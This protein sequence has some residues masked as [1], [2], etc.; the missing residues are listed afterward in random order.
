MDKNH[1]GQQWQRFIDI[2]GEIYTNGPQIRWGASVLLVYGRSATIETQSMM[3]SAAK[4]RSQL[5][6]I[7]SNYGFSQASD[8]IPYRGPRSPDQGI[9]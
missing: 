3:L 2:D 9:R 1:E 6:A 7:E 4:K 8:L 5:P